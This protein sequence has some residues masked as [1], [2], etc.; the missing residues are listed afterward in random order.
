M[1]LI[2]PHIDLSRGKLII[3]VPLTEKGKGTKRVQTAL[4]PTQEQLEQMELVEGIS[5][6]N[7][8]VDGYVVSEEANEVLSEVSRRRDK[9][10]D[11]FSGLS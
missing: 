11:S 6:W 4:D 5:I 2:V 8:T 10:R 7:H 9:K 1:V 3:D